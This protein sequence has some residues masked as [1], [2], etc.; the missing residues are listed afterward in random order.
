MGD[1]V[2]A[3][4]VTPFLLLWRENPHLNWNRKQAIELAFWFVGLFFT[5]WIVFGGRFHSALKNYPL[6]YL[7]IPI[8]VWVAF[9]LAAGTQRPQFA[10]WQR[11]PPGALCM[12]LV[13]F[14]ESLKTLLCCY[15]NRSRALWPSPLW[16]SLP[17]SPSTSARLRDL[18][19][20]SSRLRTRC[21]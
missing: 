10:P 4:V 12:G 1:A 19:L 7:C 2:G 3:V 9:P 8:L 16:L 14:Q 20:P 6:E 5:A 11:S 15:C 21:G 17:K 18:G 13:R